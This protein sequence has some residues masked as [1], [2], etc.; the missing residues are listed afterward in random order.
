M[1]SQFPLPSGPCQPSGLSVTFHCN[2]QSAALTWMPND[3][4][5]DYY[6]CA[7]AGN[8]DMLCCH[9]SNLTC[10]IEGLECGT[11]YNFSVQASDGTCN[12]SFSDFVPSG[13]GTHRR[14]SNFII[15]MLKRVSAWKLPLSPLAPCPPDAAEVRLMPM[16]MEIQVLRFSWTQVPCGDTEY[17]LTLTGSLLGDSQAL[18][19]LSSYWTNMTYFEIPLPCSSS[20]VAT[21]QSKNAAGTS[22][23][24]VELTGLTGRQHNTPQTAGFTSALLMEDVFVYLVWIPISPPPS[25]LSTIGSGVRW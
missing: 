3:N 23:K 15:F 21:L 10:T 20:Y 8:G 11:V 24:S 18:F 9:S 13:G 22:H 1:Y 17:L 14:V 6:G 2:N 19:E 4:A 7:R 12:S 5:E 16:E 25:P